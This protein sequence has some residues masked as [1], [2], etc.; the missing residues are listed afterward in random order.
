MRSPLQLSAL[1]RLPPTPRLPA[2]FVG[3]GNPMNAIE[4]NSYS[5]VWR[6]IGAA[7][8]RPQ[9]ILCVSAHWMTDGHAL[10]HIGKDAPMSLDPWRPIANG[11]YLGT[12]ASKRFPMYTR[13]NAGEVFPE[14][15]YPLSFT[16]S[17]AAWQLAGERSVTFSGLFTRKEMAGDPTA[18]GGTFGGYTYLNLSAFRVAA[19]RAPGTKVADID[20]RKVLKQSSMPE[21][22]AGTMAPVEFLDLVEY[23]ATL[24]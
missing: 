4:D 16:S 21:G 24:K 7:L 12:H 5:R 11:T 14:V 3:H 2:L 1:S 23:L 6:E 9:A 13:G 15:Q 19:V 22:Q 20:D 10:A 8:P 18:F 17:W